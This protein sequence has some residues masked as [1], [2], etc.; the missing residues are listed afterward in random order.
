MLKEGDV[1]PDFSLPDHS[2]KMV[3]ISSTDGKKRV[4]YFYPKDN[5]RVCTEQACAFRDWQ[6]DLTELGYEVIGISSDSPKTHLVF[7]ANHQLGFMLLSDVNGKVRKSFGSS[8]FFNLIPLRKTYV[9]NEKGRIEFIY[10]SFFEGKEHIEK[11]K[12]YIKNK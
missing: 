12:N 9:V 2:N 6:D 3:S 4:I 10:E 8:L 7:K 11:I 1:I 5:T